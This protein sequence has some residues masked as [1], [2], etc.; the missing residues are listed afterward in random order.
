MTEQF[1]RSL[2]WSGFALSV[3]LVLAGCA[4]Q[5]PH[6]PPVLQA[7]ANVK[8]WS[9]R[10]AL[11]V[12]SDYSTPNQSFS[13]AFEL[14]GSAE[15]GSLLLLS[16][17]GSVVA[18]LQWSPGQAMLTQGD[19]VKSSTSL[20]ALVQEV[21]GNDIPIAELFD[22]LA[23]RD[24]RSPGWTVDLS[25]I[26]EGRLSAHRSSPLPAASLRVVLEQ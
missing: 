15:N 6:Q 13:A 26:D 11:Q 14:Q 19:E 3:A 10:M 18:K 22:W 23:G 9:G 7:D 2:T 8:S 17:L 20:A 21:S 5:P 1:Q 16:P 12:D 25:R 4:S 24:V